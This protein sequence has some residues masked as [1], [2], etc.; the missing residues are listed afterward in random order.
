MFKTRCLLKI[1]GL[2]KEGAILI[3]RS[4]D[5]DNLI[6]GNKIVISHTISDEGLQYEIINTKT[7]SSA[8][9]TLEDFLRALNLALKIVRGDIIDKVN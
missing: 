9:H 6:A 8:M 1:K 7:L 5:P 3:I 4:L 2:N